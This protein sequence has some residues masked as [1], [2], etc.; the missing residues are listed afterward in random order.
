MLLGSS[1]AA[2]NQPADVAKAVSGNGHGMGVP[3]A[4]ELVHFTDAVHRL[5]DSLGEARDALV[6]ALGEAGMIDAAITA[7]V[8]RSLNI[9]ADSSGIRVDDAWEGI[10]ASLAKKTVANKF[11]TSANSPK[12]NSIIDSR[13]KH[14]R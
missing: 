11:R 4:E 3:N 8:F 14:S 1:S 10:G 13:G 5:D 2:I 7:A 6:L 9:A 12:V